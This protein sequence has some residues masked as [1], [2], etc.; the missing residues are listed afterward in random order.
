M[1]DMIRRLFPEGHRKLVFSL[2][3]LALAGVL[4]HF[5]KLD[6]NAKQA[7]IAI[8]AIFVTGNVGEHLADALKFLKGTK[9]GEIVEDIIPGDQGLKELTAEEKA[10]AAHV[11]A[12]AAH[13]AVQGA[14]VRLAEMEKKLAV[15]AQNIGQIV[16]ILNAM[17]NPNVAGP[18]KPPGQ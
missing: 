8:V 15:Q 10:E 1:S 11:A 12:S 5:G 16:Q 9:V 3:G 14:D 7:I 6:D 17:R 18:A 4:E 13:E 2:I